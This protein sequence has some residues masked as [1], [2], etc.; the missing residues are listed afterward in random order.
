MIL[1]QFH[2]NLRS[3][4]R[5]LQLQITEVDVVCGQYLRVLHTQYLKFGAAVEPVMALVVVNKV[6]HLQAEHMD[7]KH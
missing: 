3:I 1:K 6:I 7:K 2:R 5:I 4:T